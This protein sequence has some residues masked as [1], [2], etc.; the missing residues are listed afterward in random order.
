MTPHG[1]TGMAMPDQ[2]GPLKR[3]LPTPRVPAPPDSRG[4]KKKIIRRI[5]TGHN[6]S[7]G[8]PSYRAE[9]RPAGVCDVDACGR[10][11]DGQWVVRQLGTEKAARDVN[12]KK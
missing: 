7:R 8:D 5:S 6:K 12:C 2:S 9:A 3:T 1:H 11:E 10:K 4:G